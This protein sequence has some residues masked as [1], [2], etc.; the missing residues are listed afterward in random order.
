MTL[1]EY[2]GQPFKT[3]GVVKVIYNKE[4]FSELPRRVKRAI[5]A[6]LAKGRYPHL[7]DYT[8]V[9]MFDEQRKKPYKQYAL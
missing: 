4:F 6:E 2:I 7:E 8:D 1:E 9:M 5:K 3:N